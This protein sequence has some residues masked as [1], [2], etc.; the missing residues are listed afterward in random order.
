MIDEFAKE[1]LHETLQWSREALLSKL[2]GL[3]EY[4]VRR[5]LTVTGTNLLGLVKHLTRTEVMYFGDIFDRPVPELVPWRVEGAEDGIDMWASEQETR[6]EIIDRYRLS[7]E[8]SAATIDATA[9]DA[10]VHVPW[11]P[12]PDA[13][14]FNVLVHVLNEIARHT[15]HADILR[16]Q[17]DGVIG[18][19][20]QSSIQDRRGAAYWEERRAK[21]EQAARVFDH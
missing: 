4:D 17:I 13:K 16:E 19:A 14:L 2:D 3:S 8:H 7:W 12:S 15:G 20:E 9:I 1:Y 6:A 5:P 21:I 10:P 18:V 11:W